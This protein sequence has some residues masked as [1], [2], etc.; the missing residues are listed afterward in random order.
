MVVT[1]VL[2][3]KER[4][5]IRFV[6]AGGDGT[7]SWVTEIV[8]QA[9]QAAGADRVPIAVLSLGT[10]NEL[11]R[12]TGWGATYTGGSLVPFVQAVAEGR[13]VG[14][15]A[16]LWQAFPID[17]SDEVEWWSSEEDNQSPP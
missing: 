8:A 2:E 11:A 13:V 6:A 9:C 16:W 4:S 12:C 10:G 1:L 17:R 7:V 15:D 14:V 5:N 3:H